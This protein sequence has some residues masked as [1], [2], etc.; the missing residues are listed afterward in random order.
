MPQVEKRRLGDVATIFNGGTPDT[1]NVKFWGGENLWLTP[2]EMGNL[3]SRYVSTSIRKLSDAGLAA[4]SA[5]T[6]PPGSIILSS[7]APIGYVAINRLPMATNQ[8]CKGITP[9]EDLLCEYLYYFLLASN[10]LLNDLGTGA[11][12]KEISNSRLKEIEIPI[13][14]LE[15]QKLKVEKLD[16]ISKVIES[17]RSNLVNQTQDLQAISSKLIVEALRK[18]GAEKVVNLGDICQ[19][20]T[21]GTTPTSLGFQFVDNGI[22]FIKVESI[23]PSGTFLEN[24]F[25]HITEATHDAL[26]RSKLQRD[27]VLISIA[28][29]LGRSALVSPDILPANTN[30]AIALLRLSPDS[31]ISPQYLF[32]LFQAGYYREHFRKISAGAAQQN[33][34]LGQLRSLEIPVISIAAQNEFIEL[35]ADIMRETAKFNA[36]LNQSIIDLEVLFK[37][38]LKEIFRVEK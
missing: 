22:N 13:P 27:D 35:M 10:Q 2:A 11:T 16:V 32:S 1:K 37:N 14:N 4:C 28:G 24:K 12:F 18:L 26:E 19:V 15:I 20:L 29:A 17:V 5:K 7:R 38:Y 21:K 23:G 3:R 36:N 9:T 25:G 30:Q 31:E 34:S 33:L 8:G 6:L